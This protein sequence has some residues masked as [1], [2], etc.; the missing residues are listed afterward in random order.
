VHLAAI[1]HPTRPKIG[2]HTTPC[3]AVFWRLYGA[4][5]ARIYPNVS[6]FRLGVRECRAIYRV[7]IKYKPHKSLFLRHYLSAANYAHRD[8]LIQG[9]NFAPMV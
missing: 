7:I 8:W 4:N 9:Q 1:T 3:K 6:I 5:T 2:K